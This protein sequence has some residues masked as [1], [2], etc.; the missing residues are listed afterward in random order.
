MIDRLGPLSTAFLGIL[1]AI[2]LLAGIAGAISPPAWSESASPYNT[3]VVDPSDRL[4]SV[5]EAD[6]SI[7]GGGAA[8]T[9]KTVLIDLGH[10]NGVDESDIQ[11][12][13]DALVDEGHVV[14]FYSPSPRSPGADL[15]Q[16]LRSADAFVSFDPGQRFTEAEARGVADFARRGGRVLLVG[17]PPQPSPVPLVP[18]AIGPGGGSGDATLTQVSSA[19]DVALGTGYLYNMA[20]NANNFQ[21]VYA[22]PA[23][24]GPLTE[25]VER[26]LVKRAAPVVPDEG[27]QPA[28]SVTEGTR[29]STTRS[30]GTYAVAVRN[31][32]V[33][34]IGDTSLFEP[35]TVRLADNEVFVGNIVDHLVSGSKRPPRDRGSQGPPRPPDAPRRPPG[36]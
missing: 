23:R 36:S 16:S 30:S 15:N 12:L 32:D 17:E 20:E 5:P 35:D 26:V 24:S 18:G 1:L 28:L 25:G 11:P 14:R 9:E 19:F 8:P 21:H 6:G 10:A 22:T 31:G 29:L 3:S 33:V 7:E 2:L 4:A 13:V 27:I 34:V